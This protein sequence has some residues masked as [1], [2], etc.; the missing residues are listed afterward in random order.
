MPDGDQVAFAQED[1]GFAESDVATGQLCCLHNDKQRIAIS[2]DLGT[3]VR[4]LCIFDG[5]VV[6]VEF[7]LQFQQQG[8]IGLVQADPDESVMCMLQKR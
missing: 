5:Q 2:F 3:L 4:L 6:Q 8:F 1:M 7:L